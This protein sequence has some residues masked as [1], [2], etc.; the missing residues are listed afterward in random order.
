MLL[1]RAEDYCSRKGHFAREGAEGDETFSNALDPE[2][3]AE[4]A[5]D[6]EGTLEKEDTETV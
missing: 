4:G 2:E 6:K 5:D 1:H 3:I